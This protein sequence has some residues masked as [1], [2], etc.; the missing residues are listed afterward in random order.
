MVASE[1][2]EGNFH[3]MVGKSGKNHAQAEEDKEA[4]HNDVRSKCTDDDQ[5]FT[6]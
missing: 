2:I 1:G 4:R 6:R 5:Q 3:D